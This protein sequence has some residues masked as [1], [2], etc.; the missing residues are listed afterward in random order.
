MELIRKHWIK[1]AI[2]AGAAA[3]AYAYF[4]GRADAADLGSSCCSDLESRIADLEATTAR[5][6]NRKVTLNV[7]GWVAEQITYWD[8]G[9]EQNTYVGGIGSTLGTHVKFTGEAV[10]SPGWTA[11]YALHLE[12]NTND[13]LKWNQT[14]TGE[15]DLNVQQSYWFLKSDSLGKVSVGKQS[16]ASDNAAIVVDGSGS[17][18]PANWVLFDGASFAL[19]VKEIANLSPGLGGNSGGYATNIGFGGGASYTWSDLA[20]C[21]GGAVGGDCGG[22]PRNAVRYDTPTFAGFSASAAWGEDDFWDV[23][24]RYAGEFG[25]FKV[26]ATVARSEYSDP[27]LL[28]TGNN[29]ANDTTYTQG[30]LYIQHITTGLFVYGAY[31]L[32]ETDGYS[33]FDNGGP[34]DTSVPDAKTWY[35]KAGIRQKP[36]PSIGHTVFYGEYMRSDDA[37]SDALLDVAGLPGWDATG[38]QFDM[39]GLGI[40]QEI[41]AAGMSIWLKYRRMEGDADGV[42]NGLGWCFGADEGDTAHVNLEPIQFIGMGALIKF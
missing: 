29:L 19:R 10:I 36:F 13:P 22:V 32:Q 3:C 23:A 27:G 28:G 24:L 37:M 39:W 12:A 16:S 40:V 1:L 4:A 20:N 42:C 7:T 34:Q 9:Y 30:A 33:D 31:G 5:K 2:G 18:A 35:L 26:A 25:G 11:G 6:G 21:R 41:D 17:A 8:D 14:G 38:S 15:G